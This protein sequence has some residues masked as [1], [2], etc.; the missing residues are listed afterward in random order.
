MKAHTKVRKIWAI[1]VAAS[2]PVLLF[3]LLIAVS[4]RP[5]LGWVRQGRDRRAV[6]AIRDDVN[7]FQKWGTWIFTWPH[8]K[9][10]YGK[11]Y[12]FTQASAGDKKAEFQSALKNALENHESV[13]IF[14]LAHENK[15]YLWVEEIEE[16]LRARIRLV[17][18]TGCY[19]L[20]QGEKWLELGAAAYIGHPGDSASQVFYFYFL[21]RW[22]RGYR[23][24]KALEAANGLMSR[25]LFRAA[26]FSG[27]KIEAKRKWE[28]SKAGLLG[29]G[30]IAI[31][32]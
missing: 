19:N 23:A 2:L 5:F 30:E 4:D 12:Y 9:R 16:T 24:E 1:T 7:P 20:A 31:D 6:V 13:D 32:G 25:W 29:K 28:D 26:A 18:N 27:G 21:R 14:L 22:T 17:Y 15:Y 11:A 8:L 3:G 10:C